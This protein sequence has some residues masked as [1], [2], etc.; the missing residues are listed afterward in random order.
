M[1]ARRG[2]PR[3]GFTLVEAAITFALL[4][5]LLSSAILAARGGMGAFR[6]T[7][8]AT[9]VEARA[10]RALDRAVMELMGAGWTEF[11][12]PWNDLDGPLGTSNLTFAKAVAL[13]GTTPD[14]GPPLS[15]SFQYET[16][17]IDDGVDNDGNGLID[18]GVL[19]LTRDVGGPNEH[20]TILCHGVRELL[21]GEEAN[22]ADDNGN[23][24]TDEAGFSVHREGDVLRVRLSV[25]EPGEN[26]TI[27][28][29]LE[30]SVRP[31]N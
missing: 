8:G 12:P 16:G 14:F 28:R 1:R 11:D 4:G 31:R 5:L 9:D 21:E 23:T 20:R 29:T 18:D 13:N 30:T 24:V 7:Q 26:G 2:S 22:G 19:V 27:V 6:T 17:E 10:R 25:E 3:A 15:L